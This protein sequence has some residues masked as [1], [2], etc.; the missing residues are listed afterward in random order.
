MEGEEEHVTWARSKRGL[1]SAS[2]RNVTHAGSRVHSQHQQI[3]FLQSQFLLDESESI[4]AP[5]RH[6]RSALAQ[7]QSLD[8]PAQRL[9]A[10]LRHQAGNLP[11]FL[12]CAEW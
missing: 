3:R 1:R 9:F 7:S 12:T 5:D 10:R 2:D 4:A 11:S 6:H 8:E